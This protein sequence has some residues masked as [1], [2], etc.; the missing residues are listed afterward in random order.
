MTYEATKIELFGA[1]NDGQPI[2]YVYSGT[3]MA[4]KGTLVAISGATNGQRICSKALTHLE[5]APIAGVLSADASGA[6]VLGQDFP[7]V[8]VWTQGV[9]QFRCSG[10]STAGAPIA[11][12]SEIGSENWVMVCPMVNAASGGAVKIGYAMNT[13]VAQGNVGYLTPVRVNL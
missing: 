4:L 5:G 8:G 1:N 11:S 6:Y 10:A 12:V 9:F 13:G 7:R 3:S 2:D